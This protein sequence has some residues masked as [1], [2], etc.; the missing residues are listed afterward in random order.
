MADSEHSGELPD[1]VIGWWVTQIMLNVVRVLGCIGAPFPRLMRRE[2]N[3][4]LA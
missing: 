3:F 1:Q 2:V 4:F